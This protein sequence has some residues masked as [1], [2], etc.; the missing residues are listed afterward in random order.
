M[1][2]HAR[3]PYVIASSCVHE[4][5]A[6]RI[7]YCALCE[8]WGLRKN[9]SRLLTCAETLFSLMHAAKL[10]GIR[11]RLTIAC[12]VLVRTVQNRNI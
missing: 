3:V 5:R 7:T 8:F 12:M 9:R 4:Y 1:V 6:M 2:V 10:F 11:S